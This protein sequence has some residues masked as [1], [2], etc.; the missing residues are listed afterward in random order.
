VAASFGFAKVASILL[1]FGA[2]LDIENL[3]GKTASDEA[4]GECRDIF[5]I[6]QKKVCF[7]FIYL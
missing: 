6:Y 2:R 4:K 7:P 1:Y 5:D 3:E